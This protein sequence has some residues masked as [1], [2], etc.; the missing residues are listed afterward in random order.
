MF[1]SRHLVKTRINISGF[2]LVEVAVASVVFSSLLAS[3]FGLWHIGGRM[4]RAAEASGNLPH[5]MLLK[6]QILQDLLCLGMHPDQAQPIQVTQTSIDPEGAGLSFYRARFEGDDMVL[7]PVRYRV[8]F[9]RT[10]RYSLIRTVGGSDGGTSRLAEGTLNNIQF[11][12]NRPEEY[13]PVPATHVRGAPERSLEVSFTLLE[14]GV[15]E[16]TLTEEQIQSRTHV[17]VVR[18]PPRPEFGIPGDDPILS[19]VRIDM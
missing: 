6:Q 1:M 10:G 13:R 7:V 9:A 19:R 4:G 14:E 15:E 16:N 18:V 2:T 12:L 5:A 8:E 11:R 3:T 17:L